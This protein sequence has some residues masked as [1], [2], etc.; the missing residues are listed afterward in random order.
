MHTVRR[1]CFFALILFLLLLPR[2]K[3][4]AAIDSCTGSITPASWY[5]G[6]SGTLTLTITNGG[7]SAAVWIHVVGPSGGSFS[8][9]DL[10]ASGWTKTAA[11]T[12]T[13]SGGTTLPAGNSVDISLSISTVGAAVE[14]RSWTVSI[15][16]DSGG[17][18]ATTCTGS[19]S[20][21]VSGSAPAGPSFGTVT[22]SGISD[23]Q[24]T[25][26]WDTDQDSD[27][28]LN[29]GTTSDYGSTKADTTA[30]KSHS[31]TA[32]GLSANTTYHYQVTSTNAN[33]T[34]D[35]GD[36]TF[37]TA[38]VGATVS[39]VT[40]TVS[41]TV[42]R[43]VGPTPTPTPIPD[44]TPPAVTLTNDFDKPFTAAPTIKGKATD[45][46]G[47]SGKIEYSLDDGK[48]WAPVDMVDNPGAGSTTFSFTPVG[49]LDDNYIIRIRA[50]D[51]KG[52]TGVTRASWTMV[53]DRLP[54]RIGGG[55]VTL[56]PQVIPAT[57]QGAIVTVAGFH[58][59]FTVSAVGG[60]TKITLYA[61]ETPIG[62]L[63]KNSDTGLWSIPLPFDK[64]GTYRL[65]T[66]AIDGAGNTK[67]RVLNTIIVQ[68]GGTVLGAGKPIRGASVA[69]YVLDPATR[70]FV[71]WDAAAYG[72][73]NP[74]KTT[75][76][77]IYTLSLPRGAYYLRV[78]NPGFRSLVTDIFTAPDAYPV[79]S[80]ITLLP[81]R[82]FHL[83]PW[84]IRLP[85]FRQESASVAISRPS[86]EPSAQSVHPV[87]AELP[88]FSFPWDNLNITATSIRGKPTLLSFLTSWSP[89]TSG[90]LSVL[91]DLAAK[92]EINVVVVMPQESVSAVS[93]FRKRGGYKVPIIADPD[94]ILV[95]PLNI[96]SIPTH[97]FL[98]RR[99]TIQSVVSGVL[100]KEEILDRL[101]Q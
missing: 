87:G 5:I 37:T 8:L 36:Q 81:T 63:Q 100:S 2:Q 73:Q 30:T 22:V 66:H 44:R 68:S 90:Q 41:T 28:T 33:G 4:H 46:S 86:I 51:G 26:S 9:N 71:L 10:S 61:N 50:T 64:P 56:G 1:L 55:I 47:V 85:D 60:P 16:D 99:G 49:L 6:S 62:D 24:A 48:S 65:S 42:T 43:I 96:Q 38:A 40:T 76:A 57:P 92:K 39:T 53:V 69:V 15:S 79:T 11:G 78:T 91:G 95:E 35:S 97:V 80:S 70:R 17:S 25:I 12:L 3:A 94:G 52:N 74:Q 23:T 19:L 20:T 89:Q 45:P 18:G 7:A 93:I 59:T 14:A 98:N 82:S 29:W 72:A 34:A 13:P 83:G 101:I 88:Y 77:G 67:D 54:P 21:A 58:P 75:D 32:T 31:L 27:S 84:V